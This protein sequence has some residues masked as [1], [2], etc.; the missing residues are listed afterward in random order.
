MKRI[1]GAGLG[2]MGVVALASAVW[3]AVAGLVSGLLVAVL[4][5]GGGTLAVLGG[6]R[7]RAE[8]VWRRELRTLPLPSTYGDATAAPTLAELRESA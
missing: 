7:V 3:P 1:V 8:L 2:A 6:R 5:A 4:C